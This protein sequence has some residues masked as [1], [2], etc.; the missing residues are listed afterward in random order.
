MKLDNEFSLGIFTTPPSP[1]IHQ[2]TEG[3]SEENRKCIPR[4]E[5][6]SNLYDFLDNYDPFRF[7]SKSIRERRLGSCRSS[8]LPGDGYESPSASSSLVTLLFPHYSRRWCIPFLANP[9]LEFH[10]F[11]SASRGIE[12]NSKLFEGIRSDM[13]T[14]LKLFLCYIFLKIVIAPVRDVPL[15][16]LA[17]SWKPMNPDQGIKKKK[18]TKIRGRFDP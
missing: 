8:I 17:F 12:S 1:L 15:L 13:F 9:Y 14:R 3:E 2:S 11:L 5:L 6:S 18:N 7:F 10:G 16:V 4:I